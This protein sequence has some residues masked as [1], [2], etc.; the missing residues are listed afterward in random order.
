M[1]GRYELARTHAVWFPRYAE[2][3]REQTAEAIRQGQRIGD[4]AYAA[5]LRARAAFRDRLVAA[6]DRDGIDLWI[7][8]AATGPAPYG[9]QSTGDSVMSLPWSYAGVPALALPAG[10]AANSL[11]LGVQCVAR[12]GADER[13]LGWALDLESTLVGSSTPV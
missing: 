1:I 10:R 5:A 7:T 2:R 11:P 9:L 3:Y 6:M 4:D 8:P 12:P 13:L